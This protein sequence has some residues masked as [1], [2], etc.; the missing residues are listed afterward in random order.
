MKKMFG[1]KLV[2]LF[3]VLVWLTACAKSNYQD[4]VAGNPQGPALEKPDAPV[5]YQLQLVRL[6]LGLQMTWEVR[7]TD[8]TTGSLVLE[9][10]DL[11]NPGQPIGMELFPKITLWMPSMGHGSS[12]VKIQK[13]SNGK[14]RAYNI[15]FVMPGDWD[16]RIQIKNNSG[17]V[18]DAVQKISI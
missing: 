14:F 3:F 18:D 4:P 15:F 10:S 13:L 1:N 9:F 6:Y 7:P 16:I 2:P 12:P 11:K 8:K 5:K 17:E